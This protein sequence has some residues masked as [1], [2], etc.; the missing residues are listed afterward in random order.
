MSEEPIIC[1]ICGKKLKSSQ[2]LAGHMQ[3]AH[4]TL[5]QRKKMPRGGERVDRFAELRDFVDL[6]Y[7]LVMARYLELEIQR[8]ERELASSASSAQQNIQPS[9]VIY[10]PSTPQE[11]RNLCPVCNRPISEH[12][13]PRQRARQARREGV[14][15]AY[16]CP[17]CGAS[18]YPS[19]GF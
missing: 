17:S 19:N 11:S 12:Y 16:P 1:E 3:L 14:K 8:L 13:V 10:L 18:L 6:R 15:S 2:G 7:K 4:G 9:N 5:A